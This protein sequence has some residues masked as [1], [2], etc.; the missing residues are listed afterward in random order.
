MTAGSTQLNPVPDSGRTLIP[1]VSMTDM[2]AAAMTAILVLHSVNGFGR[3]ADTINTIA[4]GYRSDST[5][6]DREIICIFVRHWCWN[7]KCR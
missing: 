2:V 3:N 6:E 4:I 7:R 1:A 5:G